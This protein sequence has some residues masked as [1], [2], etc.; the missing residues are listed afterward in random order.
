[1]TSTSTRPGAVLFDLDGTLVNSEPI[2]ETALV[3]LAAELGGVM[4]VAARTACVGTDMTRTV[5]IVHV[6][7]GVT[8]DID[9]S[10]RYLWRRA[11]ELF[12]EDV[13]VRPG[14]VDLVAAVRAAGIPSAI[15]TTTQRNLATALLR[16][17]GADRFD[18]IVCGDDV[19]RRKPHPEPY[20]TAAAGLGVDPRTAVAIEDSPSGVTSALAAGCSVV[21]VPGDAP[22]EP[23]AGVVVRDTL[24]GV[25]TSWL[26]ALVDEAA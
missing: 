5:E 8:A 21:A 9:E 16:P 13:P 19:A 1:M 26:A 10:S 12:A 6:D 24:V 20:L 7:L 22:V 2:W 15:V 18:L 14:A 17:L 4:S 11:G 25:T 23:R 3:E